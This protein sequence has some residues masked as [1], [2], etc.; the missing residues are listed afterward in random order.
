M[1]AARILRSILTMLC[2]PPF[3]WDA[4]KSGAPLNSDVRRH[5]NPHASC[6]SLKQLQ[7]IYTPS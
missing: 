1:V 7:L 4:P 5:E 6:G 3:E 2:Y